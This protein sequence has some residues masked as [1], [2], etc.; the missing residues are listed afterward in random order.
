M[1]HSD[2]KSGLERVKNLEALYPKL[3]S[4]GRKMTFEEALKKTRERHA[5]VIRLLMNN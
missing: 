4:H 3:K 1:S 5:E 2:I